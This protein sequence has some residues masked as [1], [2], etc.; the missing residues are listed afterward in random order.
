MTLVPRCT[1][2]PCYSPLACSGWRYCRQRNFENGVPDAE[3]QA[4]WADLDRATS[5]QSDGSGPA[6]HFFEQDTNVND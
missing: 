1:A 2:A 4:A 6:S 5:D 3:T